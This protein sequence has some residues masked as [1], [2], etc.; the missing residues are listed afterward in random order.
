MVLFFLFFFFFCA[1]FCSFLLSLSFLCLDST[2]N[3]DSLSSY[4]CGFEPL[5]HSH[6]TFCMKFFLVA[7]IFIV[8]D[9]EIGFI[10]PCLFVSTV[11]FS[12][13]L[14]VLVGLLF[15]YTFGGLDWV[16]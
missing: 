3:T 4:E 16:A 15:E 6:C 14:V 12:F 13:T 9:V 1:L 8:F 7:I 10:I 5:G 2:T 11:A